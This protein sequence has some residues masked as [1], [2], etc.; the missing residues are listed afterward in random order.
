MDDFMPL[1]K[2][3]P[4]ALVANKTLVVTI[5]YEYIYILLYVWF[6]KH[7]GYNLKLDINHYT[8]LSFIFLAK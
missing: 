1:Q 3:V 4:V 5:V 2:H 7:T 8:T 6:T